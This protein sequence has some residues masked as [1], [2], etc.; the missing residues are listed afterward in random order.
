MIPLSENT[1]RI[2]YKTPGRLSPRPGGGL[3]AGEKDG[4]GSDCLG[5][6]IPDNCID[7]RRRRWHISGEIRGRVHR[8]TADEPGATAGLGEAW[9]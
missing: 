6:G 8:G 4:A 3:E 7:S 9:R 5:A 1:F 2:P